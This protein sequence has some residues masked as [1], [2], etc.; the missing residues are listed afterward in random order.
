VP[1]GPLTQ[2]VLLVDD[3]AV[4]ALSLGDV[5]ELWGYEPVVAH[6]GADALEAAEAGPYRAALVD[7]KLPD[8][9]G[10]ELSGRLRARRPEARVVLMSGF[11]F[12]QALREI[13][14]PGGVAIVRQAGD[15]APVVA[16]VAR[17]PAGGVVLVTSEDRTLA[18]R[19][20]RALRRDGRRARAWASDADE[21]PPPEVLVA[22]PATPL[23]EVVAGWRG[24]RARASPCPTLVLVTH[25]PAGVDPLGDPSRTGCLL[26]PFEPHVA[27]ALLATATP[28]GADVV[29]RRE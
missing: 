9:D 24:L 5:F 15:P 11:R 2:R 29:W 21:A 13:T 10:F 3:N 4:L 8:C 17:V 25:A 12:D 7:V 23:A 26:K 22:C 20:I 14:G 27:A 6:C 1:R 28:G 16:A 18:E 19:A